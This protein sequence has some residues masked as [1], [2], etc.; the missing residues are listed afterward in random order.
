MFKYKFL[1]NHIEAFTM[2]AAHVHNND[3]EAAAILS[4]IFPCLVLLIFNAEYFRLLF[5]SGLK[6]PS[7]YIRT[8][9]GASIFCTFGLL[10]TVIISTVSRLTRIIS[11]LNINLR[12]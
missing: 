4:M 10:A 5:W 2:M 8:K 7:W 12:S 9:K 1:Q 3:I 6:Q 11:L